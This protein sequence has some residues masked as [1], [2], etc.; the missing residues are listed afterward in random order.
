M[1]SE[2]ELLKFRGLFIQQFDKCTSPKDLLL[3]RPINLHTLLLLN[4][5]ELWFSHPYDFNDPFDCSKTSHIYLG[6]IDYTEILQEIRVR[7]FS[8]SSNLNNMLLWAHYA[9][10]HRG[11]AVTVRPNYQKLRE[12][13]IAISPIFYHLPPIPTPYSGG[14]EIINDMFLKKDPIWEYEK[15]YRLITLSTYL[16][17]GHILRSDTTQPYFSIQNIIFGL[18]CPPDYRK[19]IKKI[20]KV[21]FFEMI[22]VLGNNKDPI[23]KSKQLL[24]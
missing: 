1:P 22:K 17:K 5:F 7:S 2:E 6:A 24:I 11:I 13:H 10:G 12:K 18:K 9:D 19:L 16:A 20:I 8:I 21:P 23:I 15:E 14:I 4:N 3:F